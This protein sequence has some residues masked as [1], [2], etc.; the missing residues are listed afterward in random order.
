MGNTW[1]KRDVMTEGEILWK[2]IR[3]GRGKSRRA[4]RE[5][6]KEEETRGPDFFGETGRHR[7]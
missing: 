7:V 3:R 5:I 6:D 4:R 2:R 1:S